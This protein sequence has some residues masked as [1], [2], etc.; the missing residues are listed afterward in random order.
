MSNHTHSSLSACVTL[1]ITC[2]YHRMDF[3][4]TV[5]TR[6]QFQSSTKSLFQIESA[7]IGTSKALN[8]SRPDV[9]SRY[10]NQQ[11]DLNPIGLELNH[12]KLAQAVPWLVPVKIGEAT[13]PWHLHLL[14]LLQPHLLSSSASA[15]HGSRWLCW[16]SW[17]QRMCHSAS[18]QQA[19]QI[20]YRPE[21]TPRR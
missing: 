8:R 11:L 2:P 16:I 20:R 9:A 19:G 12:F 18:G 1:Q 4:T 7:H 5:Q 3:F 21:V 13:S 17:W 6:I 15:S 14:T 10:I